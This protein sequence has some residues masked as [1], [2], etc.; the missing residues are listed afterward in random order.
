M[1]FS[2]FNVSKMMGGPVK[3][4]YCYEGEA[5]HVGTQDVHMY[6]STS[7]D[8]FIFIY[9]YVH[10]YINVYIHI[11]RDSVGVLGGSSTSIEVP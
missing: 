9:I 5:G 8:V 11:H 7:I 10:I 2:A 1:W 4:I 6:M 3:G